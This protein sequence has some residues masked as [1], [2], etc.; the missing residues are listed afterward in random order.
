ME[1]EEKTKLYSECVIV[2]VIYFMN[3]KMFIVDSIIRF[4]IRE[5]INNNEIRKYTFYKEREKE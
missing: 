2:I 4:S 1:F 5:D 3:A